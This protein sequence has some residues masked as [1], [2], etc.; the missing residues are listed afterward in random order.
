MRAWLHWYGQQK[1]MCTYLF[2]PA[3]SLSKMAISKNYR[4]RFNE[5]CQTNDVKVEKTFKSGPSSDPHYQC[6]T[7]YTHDS[8]QGSFV[9]GLHPNK[10]AAE[11]EAAM[12]A[13]VHELLKQEVKTLGKT[14][15]TLLHEHCAK[16][17]L[18]CAYDTKR[19]TEQTFYSKLEISEEGSKLPVI[20]SVQGDIFGNKA[21]A[22]HSAA[23]RALSRLGVISITL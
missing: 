18:L 10:K 3:V 19:V 17:R 5:W 12:R 21:A 6:N 23:L 4:V 16:H 15:K 11:E 14:P 2:I 20:E 9:S 22:E 13:M 7:T 1:C 8:Q